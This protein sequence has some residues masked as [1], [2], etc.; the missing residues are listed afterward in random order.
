MNC[1]IFCHMETLNLCGARPHAQRGSL[2]MGEARARPRDAV[3]RMAGV[4]AMKVHVASRRKRLT[5]Q[6]KNRWSSRY[7]TPG[8]S[9]E[10]CV[11]G[12]S[13]GE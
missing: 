9:L 10:R 12:R 13:E 11:L 3:K 5:P 2:G 4:S 7:L 1:G 6:E 8:I